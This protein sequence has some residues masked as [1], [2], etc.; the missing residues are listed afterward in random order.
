MRAHWEM[1]PDTCNYYNPPL[2]RISP[3]PQA[4]SCCDTEDSGRTLSLR[5]ELKE[6]RDTFEPSHIQLHQ[7][8]RK[9][10]GRRSL[11][12][13]RWP[14]RKSDIKNTIESWPQFQFLFRKRLMFIKTQKL[15]ANYV[16]RRTNR[17]GKEKRSNRTS[18]QQ[19]SDRK[20]GPGNISLGKGTDFWSACFHRFS[21]STQ[22]NPKVIVQIGFIDKQCHY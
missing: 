1:P 20:Y 13:N 18:W 6:K 12:Y 10:R 16:S 22:G 15:G 2:S 8:S 4:W 17:N 11:Q 19:L 9:H 3:R 7:I 5:W 14:P 21:H